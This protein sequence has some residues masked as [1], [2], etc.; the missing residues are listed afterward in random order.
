MTLDTLSTIAL[1]GAFLA[2]FG[3]T[4][5]D[6]LRH[7]DP[8]RRAVVLVFACLAAV[9]VS[10][11]IRAVA[12]ALAPATG[13]IVLPA[14]LAQ[15]VLVLWLVSLVRPIPRAFL[16]GAV[17]SL[18]AFTAAIVA[19][20]AGSGAARGTPAVVQPLLDALTAARRI[21]AVLPE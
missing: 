9:L 6:Y 13:L 19:L 1:D 16:A 18:I 4:L 10:P 7:R 17:L 8:V 14:L 12:P 20:L 5:I 21:G 11:L 3:F 15:P 2:V